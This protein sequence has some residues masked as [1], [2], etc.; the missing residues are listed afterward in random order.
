MHIHGG[1][2]EVVVNQCELQLIEVTR[3]RKGP[4]QSSLVAQ[5][6]KDLFHCCGSGH[7]SG[8]GLIPSPG[9]FACLAK[10]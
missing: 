1:A 2:W 6:V 4:H 9:T 8:A 3:V 10:K 5:W 7:C